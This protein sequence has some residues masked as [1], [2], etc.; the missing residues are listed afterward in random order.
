VLIKVAD[1]LRQQ[2]SDLRVIAVGRN[3]SELEIRARQLPNVDLRGYVG[4]D[5]GLPELMRNAAALLM[6]SRYETFGIPVAEAMAAGTPV[7]ASRGGALP[8][9]IGDAGVFV[10]LDDPAEIARAAEDLS[11]DAGRRTAM[12]ER[13]RRRAEDYRWEACVDRLVNSFFHRRPKLPC[14]IRVET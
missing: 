11:R 10:E 1:H 2:R 9:V 13:G 3:D 8:E 4:A 14:S 12:I 5:T 7:I 6:L